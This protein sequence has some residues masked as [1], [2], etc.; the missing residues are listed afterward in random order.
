[1][2]TKYKCNEVFK[3]IKFEEEIDKY[4]NIF[5]SEVRLANAKRVAFSLTEQFIEQEDLTDEDVEKVLEKGCS[6]VAWK[7][8][9]MFSR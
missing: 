6:N 5:S 2:A 4:K 1:M 8:V 3:K 7:I 9:L